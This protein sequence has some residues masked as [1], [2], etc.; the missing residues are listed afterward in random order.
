M[1]KKVLI[2]I[3]G[4]VDS[5]V[6]AWHLLNSGYDVRG[7]FMDF[8]RATP[9]KK[10]AQ[11]LEDARMVSKRLKMPLRVLDL[12]SDF[13]RYVVKYFYQEYASGRTPNPCIVCNQKIKFAYLLK[14]AGK[15]GVDYISTGHYARIEY[16]AGRKRFFLKEGADKIKDQSYM[17]FCLKQRVLRR[18]LFPL[19]DYTKKEVRQ[20][21][22]KLGLE[23]YNRRDS[24]DICFVNN[25]YRQ[26]LKNVSPAGF[27]A[28]S[29]ID[30]KG[31]ILGT[32]N[33]TPHF[34]VGQRKGLGL[35]REKPLYVTSIDSKKNVVVVGSKKE[36]NNDRLSA[37]RLNWIACRTPSFP[38]RAEAKIRYKHPK[39]WGTVSSASGRIE[40]TF[41]RP[42]PAISPGQAVVFYQ[43]KTVLGGGWIDG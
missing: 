37:S 2:A 3:S 12:K 11:N 14:M 8:F 19:G 32:H 31:N 35:A 42:Q 36:I 15:M 22:G 39:A 4:G 13:E 26:F 40:V 5:S 9:P 24:Q 16:D 23:N 17:L 21:A 18:T 28:G 20:I 43:G 25:D 33:G 41:D 30:A 38:F 1:K 7:V 34:T 27:L 10:I 29:I 6:A